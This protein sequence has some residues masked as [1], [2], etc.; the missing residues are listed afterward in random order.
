M[1]VWT[2]V[3]SVDHVPHVSVGGLSLDR[4]YKGRI[5][6]FQSHS[7]G[8]RDFSRW[9]NTHIDQQMFHV[10]WWTELKCVLWTDRIWTSWRLWGNLFLSSERCSARSRAVVCWRSIWW[11]QSWLF[12][13]QFYGCWIWFFKP[14]PPTIWSWALWRPDRTNSNSLE[15]RSEALLTG[16]TPPK[17]PLDPSCRRNECPSGSGPSNGWLHNIQ[18]VDLNTSGMFCI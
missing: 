12:W 4:P 17:D 7:A 10:L 5:T 11:G 14:S 6:E 9:A 3:W 2:C 13:G 1:S 18:A 15:S 8:R 16:Y